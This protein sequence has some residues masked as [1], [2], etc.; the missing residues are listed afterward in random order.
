MSPP[1]SFSRRASCGIAG[2]PHQ[3]VSPNTL[4]Q[5]LPAGGGVGLVAIGVWLT[6]TSSATG[7]AVTTGAGVGD[8]GDAGGAPLHQAAHRPY[9]IT[10]I[11][12]I[13]E[14][15]RGRI[16]NSLA[17]GGSPPKCN[18][19]ILCIGYETRRNYSRSVVA[20]FC[21]GAAGGGANGSGSF[22]ADGPPTGRSLA[23]SFRLGEA[24][25]RISNQYLL[26]RRDDVERRHR[27]RYRYSVAGPRLAQQQ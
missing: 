17:Q 5:L 27:S 10:S 23:S 13:K 7:G 15:G 21:T 9:P 11:S 26:P 19:S 14:G 2:D 25:G 3:P 6:G 8:V 16:S 18:S 4:I 24:Q 12:P 1:R 20:H 22:L